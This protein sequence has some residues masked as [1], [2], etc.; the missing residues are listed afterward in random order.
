MVEIDLSQQG[1]K[2]KLIELKEGKVNEHLLQLIEGDRLDASG[3]SKD[4]LDAPLTEK[5]RQQAQRMVK[6]Q[7]R[8]KEVVRFVTLDR[9]YEISDVIE[10]FI[11]PDTVVIEHFLPEL[12]KQRI[13][14]KIV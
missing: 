12:S 9:G 14:T 4:P 1:R 13:F 6:Q 7:K 8:M 3:Q 10:T 5:S 2:W 11:T